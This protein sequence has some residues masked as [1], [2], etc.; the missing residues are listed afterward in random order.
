VT[1]NIII[2]VILIL[3]VIVI[4]II[5]VRKTS[6]PAWNRQAQQDIHN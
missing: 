3:I 2:I 4:M 1:I 5:N 6:L